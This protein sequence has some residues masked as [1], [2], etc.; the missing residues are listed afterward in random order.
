MTHINIDFSK[1]DTIEFDIDATTEEA[2][3]GTSFVLAEYIFHA[4][5]ETGDETLV[6]TLFQE[7]LASTATRYNEL[8]AQANEEKSAPKEDQ[9]EVADNVITLNTENFTK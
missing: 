3:Q 7:F 2:L 6:D 5:K 9:A 8:A 4:V 1:N